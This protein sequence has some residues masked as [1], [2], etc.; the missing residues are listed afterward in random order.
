MLWHSDFN[1]PFA[2]L[3]LHYCLLSKMMLLLISFSGAQNLNHSSRS[4]NGMILDFF[5]LCGNWLEEDHGLMKSTDDAKSY[6]GVST[7]SSTK[8]LN[9]TITAD[10]VDWLRSH[11]LSTWIFLSSSWCQKWP[12]G[13]QHWENYRSE[14]AINWVI[15]HWVI[16]LRVWRSPHPSMP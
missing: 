7:T 3:K 9:E 11:S 2:P 12:K 4:A 16:K 5:F 1:H 14:S 10:I 15:S 13:W 6:V 8:S